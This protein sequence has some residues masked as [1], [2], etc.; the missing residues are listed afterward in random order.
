[1]EPK[2]KCVL[3]VDDTPSYLML[4]NMILQKQYAV[5]A[6]PKGE[7]ALK[8]ARQDPA[9]VDLILLDIMMDGMDGF[10]VCQELKADPATAQIPVIF[11]SG[12]EDRAE[13]EK[14]LALGAADFLLKPFAAEAVLAAVAKHLPTE[15]VLHQ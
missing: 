10:A 11:I 2:K 4:L 3:A 8:I 14:G 13:Q 9:A 1:M 15:P 12:K 5:K 7:T 6:V